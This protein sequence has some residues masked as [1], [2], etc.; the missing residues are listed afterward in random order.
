M[1]P[2]V[3]MRM[4]R[5][6][7]PLKTAGQNAADKCGRHHSHRQPVFQHCI[8]RQSQHLGARTA[9]PVHFRVSTGHGRMF[10]NDVGKAHGKKSTTASPVQTMAGLRPKAPSNS[11]FRNPFSVTVTGVVPRLAVR[12]QAARFTT[13]QRFSFLRV[14]SAN[15]FLRIC[16]A[17]GFD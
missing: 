3:K 8:G 11:S 2:S 7:R 15:T 13:R 12:L 16:A 1:S 9:Q 14:L 4:P 5:I 6:R 10:I 17:D